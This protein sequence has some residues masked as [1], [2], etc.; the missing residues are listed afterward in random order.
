MAVIAV[1]E[2]IRMS[3]ARRVQLRIRCTVEV[4]G[5]AGRDVSPA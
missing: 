4:R 5:S 2:A 1:P 3:V